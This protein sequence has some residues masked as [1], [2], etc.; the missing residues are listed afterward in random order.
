MKMLNLRH[1]SKIHGFMPNLFVYG[2]LLFPEILEGLTRIPLVTKPAK[3]QGFK[4]YRVQGCDYPAVVREMNSLVEGKLVFGIDNQLI[5]I[6]TFFEGDS[7]KKIETTIQLENESLT[8]A[9]FIWKDD[10][11]YLAKEDW[12]S[13]EFK[14]SSLNFYIEEVVPETVKEFYREL[15]G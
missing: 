10:L 4:R 5:D 14:Q 15:P 6:L 7:Y 8:A 9:V 2:T 3:L 12:D 1:H 11:D 13:N